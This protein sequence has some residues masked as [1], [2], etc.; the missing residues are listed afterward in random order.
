MSFYRENYCLQRAP[1][2]LCFYVFTAGIMHVTSC[3]YYH[4]IT[5]FDLKGSR[6]LCKCLSTQKIRNLGW[7]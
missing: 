6:D 7:G 3:K 4:Y 5:C 1:V 2:F